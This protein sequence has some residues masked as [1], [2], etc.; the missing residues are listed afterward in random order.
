VVEFI[1]ATYG[2][3]KVQELVAQFRAAT[4][5]EEALQQVL[6]ISVDEL[7]AQWRATLPEVA[8]I[9][10][11]APGPQRAPPDRFDNGPAGAIAVPD[12]NEAFDELFAGMPNWGFLAIAMT[13]LVTLVVVGGGLLLMVLRVIGV[14]K[15]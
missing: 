10:T 7:D 14:D 8:A 3:A 6:G 2:E 5:V 9:P 11:P 1:I 15:R 13:C 4:P 12:A